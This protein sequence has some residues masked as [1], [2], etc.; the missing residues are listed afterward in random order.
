MK[1]KLLLFGPIG[2]FG[3]RDVEV[4]IIAQS[5][6]NHY[7]ISI[8]STKYF[9]RKSYALRNL[10]SVSATSFQ[11]ELYKSSCFIRFW[12]YVMYLKNNKK[13]QPYA[14]VQNAVSKRFFNFEK[15]KEAIVTR[16]ITESDVVIA[17]V[18]PSSAYLKTALE[19][20]ARQKKPFWIRTTGTIRTLQPEMFDFLKKAT[21]FIHHSQA[22]ALNLNRQLPLPYV[23]ID[24]CAQEEQKL[25]ALPIPEKKMVFGYLGRLSPEKGILELIRFFQNYPEGQLRISGNGPLQQEVLDTIKD[26]DN[27]RYLGQSHPDELQLFFAPISV[28]IIPSH[29]ESGPLVGLE[30]MASGRLIISTEVGAMKER[31]AGTKND[32]WFQI[33]H[34]HSFFDSLAA[35]NA[36]PNEAF[37][38][39]A[40]NNRQRYL[41]EYQF[42]AI[43]QKYRNC[44]E[45]DVTP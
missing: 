15:K 26:Y 16:C 8:V 34:P 13:Q 24:Q 35:V 29:E 19:I 1:K 43:Q 21:G 20:S 31:L 42:S 39:I 17:C 18:Q 45:N 3:G 25:L 22:N 44:L 41:A 37:H 30:A 27:I 2:D 12:A 36:L 10:P 7:E 23:I 33:N 5:L 9:T 4:N 11:Q 32:F 6:S 28:L 38:E 14:Y 40:Q